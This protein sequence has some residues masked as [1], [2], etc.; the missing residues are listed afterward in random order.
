MEVDSWVGMTQMGVMPSMTRERAPF[1]R[2]QASSMYSVAAYSF[3]NGVVELPYVLTMST[4][5]IATYYWL[6]GMSTDM[7]KLG[8]Y[9]IFFTTYLVAMVFLGQFL[10]C[11][12]PNQQTGQVAGSALIAIFNLFGGYLCSPPTIKSFWK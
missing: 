6:V 8:Y 10:I 12:L 11:L 4:L 1:Y 7:D 9:W 5:F 2:E 3:A